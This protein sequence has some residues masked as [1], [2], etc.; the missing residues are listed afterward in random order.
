MISFGCKYLL[1]DNHFSADL[2]EAEVMQH[3]VFDHSSHRAAVEPADKAREKQYVLSEESTERKTEERLFQNESKRTAPSPSS[4]T[5]DYTTVFCFVF[6]CDE[7]QLLFESFCPCPW[8]MTSMVQNTQTQDLGEG[9]GRKKCH[10][11]V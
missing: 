6:V 7:T 1:T 11:A 9:E 5:L 8:R 10:T 4:N 3:L 2:A